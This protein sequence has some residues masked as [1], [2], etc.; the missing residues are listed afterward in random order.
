M[1]FIS[2]LAFSKGDGWLYRRVDAID[3]ISGSL[4]LTGYII[5]ALLKKEQF[6]AGAEREKRMARFALGLGIGFMLSGILAS[7][8]HISFWKQCTRF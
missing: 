1:M 7:V 6:Q 5:I 2:M 4:S 3:W 8:V